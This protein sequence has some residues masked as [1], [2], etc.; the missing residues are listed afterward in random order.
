MSPRAFDRYMVA[1]G[2]ARHVKFRRLSDAERLAFFLGVLSI[3]AQAPVRGRLLIG[4][5]RAEP[6]DIAAEA[7]VK[8]AV[9]RSCMSKLRDVGVLV[10]DVEFGCERVH[11]FDDWNP[12]P[13]RDR[14]AADR[15]ARRR[16][17]IQAEQARHA[18]VTPASRRDVTRD[19]RDGHAPEVEGEG[20]N[21]PSSGALSP[22]AHALE[23][24]TGER[25]LRVIG[26]GA[27]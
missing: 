19:D 10:D 20:E 8:V 11:D 9:A 13:R 12:P 1:V 21:S 5:L 6:E 23:S 18:R 14:T 26:G 22:S 2:A 24:A 16:A 7:A 27:A 3:A 15:Q 25:G 4:D 17:R